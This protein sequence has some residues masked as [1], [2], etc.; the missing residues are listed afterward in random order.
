MGV[1]RSA[2]TADIYTHVRDVFLQSLSTEEFHAVEFYTSSGYKLINQYMMNPATITDERTQNGYDTIIENL[3]NALK[4]SNPGV[5]LPTLYRGTKQKHIKGVQVGD[6]YTLPFFLST[7][8][9]PVVAS[10]FAGDDEP[11]VI[12][13][14]NV[15]MCYG[16]VSWMSQENEV[17]L[18]ATSRLVVTSIETNA[19]FQPEYDQSGFC[20]PAKKHVTIVKAVLEETE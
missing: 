1:Y 15:N 18:P 14:E 10:R 5:S 16:G 12:I 11:A 20:A 2:V 17:L 13:V 3:Q 8:T 9:D 4:R 19:T 7:S 6:V